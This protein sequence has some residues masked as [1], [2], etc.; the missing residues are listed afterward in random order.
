MILKIELTEQEAQLILNA[1]GELKAVVS[2]DL[3]TK[4]KH[5]FE[6]QIKNNNIVE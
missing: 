1:L 5:D 2:F 6:E 4:L 3:I